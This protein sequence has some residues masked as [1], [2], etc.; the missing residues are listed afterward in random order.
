MAKRG[1]TKNVILDAA[2]AVFFEYGFEASSVKMIIEKAGVVT[3]SFYHFFPSKELLLE[4]VVERYLQE[5]SL[6]ISKIF[7]DETLGLYEIMDKFIG[8]L[9]TVSTMYYDVLQG[10]K[11]HWTLQYALHDKT[12]ER[13]IPSVVRMLSRFEGSG[14]IGK[15]I[16]LDDVTLAVLLVRGGELIIHTEKKKDMS[17]EAIMT[18]KQKMF[19]YLH[20]FILIGTK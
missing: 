16:D 15:V 9:T 19:D 13:L 18:I 10:D 7:E 17:P 20:K 6:R 11:L 14:E 1:E 5:Y 4:A 3:G 12:I 8:E 2:T